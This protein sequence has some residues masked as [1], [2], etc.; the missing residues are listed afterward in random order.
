MSSKKRRKISELLK[1]KTV[2]G[3]I[4]VAGWVRTARK[5]KGILFVELSDGSSFGTLQLVIE[6]TKV[7]ADLDEIKTGAAIVAEGIIAESPGKEQSIELQVTRIEVT[8]PVD[9][10]YPLQKKRHSYEFLREIPHLRGK[11]KLFQAVFSIRS[12]LSYIIHR[13]FQEKGF[14]Y[15]HAPMFTKSDCEGGGETFRVDSSKV[16]GEDIFLSV[17]GQLEV[18]PFA[19]S[20]GEVYTFAPCFRADP[21]DTPR[22][23]AEFWMIEPE[24]AFYDFDD[25]K[26]IIEEFIKYCAAELKR[27]C[28]KELE[29]FGKFVEPELE[30][31]FE[32]LLGEGFAAISFKEALELLRSSGEKFEQEPSWEKDLSTEHERYLTEKQFK[33]PVFITDYPESFK[34]FYMRLS[35]DG[36]IVTGSQREER[37]ETLLKRMEEKGLDMAEYKWYLET[38]KWG[39]APHSG[40]GIGLERLLMYLTGVK[41]IKDVTPYPR[42]GGRVY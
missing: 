17:S 13:F 38:R 26:E 12:K 23:A 9:E 27:E 11:T 15:I 36:E 22:H 31:R 24:M 41:S 21:S 32:T 2:S 39:S 30:E 28:A 40:F 29:F 25:L 8:G 6:L 35:D 1:T 7:A 20:H 33:K 18:E 5:G 37:Y 34:P 19:L 4:K 16:F 14:T 42:A 10:Q 3:A